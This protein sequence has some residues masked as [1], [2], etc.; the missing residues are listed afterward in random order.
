MGVVSRIY[1]IPQVKDSFKKVYKAMFQASSF[2]LFALAVFLIYSF[3]M[4]AINQ[5][6]T[7]YDEAI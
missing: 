4:Q 1:L 5:N 3:L 7:I 6:R 2:L